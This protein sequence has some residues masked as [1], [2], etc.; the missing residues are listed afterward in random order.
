M[1]THLKFVLWWCQAHAFLLTCAF[2]LGKSLGL[3]IDAVLDILKLVDF[4]SLERS[5]EKNVFI[6]LSTVWNWSGQLQANLAVKHKHCTP[7]HKHS[8]KTKK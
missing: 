8:A 4:C 7:H 5:V 3:L 1:E 2:E 6:F